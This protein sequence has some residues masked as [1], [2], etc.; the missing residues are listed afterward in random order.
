MEQQKRYPIL[1][2]IL[3]IL[4]LSCV[5]VF[6]N[7][8]Q[9][10]TD[11]LPLLSLVIPNGDLIGGTDL[12]YYF[13]NHTIIIPFESENNL[14]GRV[15]TFALQDSSLVLVKR[16]PFGRVEAIDLTGKSKFSLSTNKE[17]PNRPVAAKL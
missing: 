10:S 2:Q 6:A 13:S 16:Q 5:F 12:S 8:S 9:K 1:V 14:N 11:S 15:N 17:G 4:S 7:C 3:T